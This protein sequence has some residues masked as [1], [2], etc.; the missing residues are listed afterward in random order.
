MEL[1]CN[2]KQ[3]YNLIAERKA[4]LG[5]I[6]TNCV[7]SSEA[8]ERYISLNRFL[9]E[10]GESGIF[11]FSD[12][13]NYYQLY[14]YLQEG[15][16]F[17][18]EK[19]NKPVLVQN[20][21]RE[22]KEDKFLSFL[23]VQ[24]KNN[25]F[26][27]KDTLSHAVLR[28][29]NILFETLEKSVKRIERIFLKEGFVFKNVAIE[30]LS[31]LKEFMLHIEE[32][33]FYQYPYYTDEEYIEEANE[34]RLS[35]IVDKEGKIIAA[36]HL[37]VAGKKAYGWVGI[38]KEYKALYGFAPYILYQQLIYLRKNNIVMCSWVKTTNTPSIQYHNRIGSAWSGQ[39]ED[40]WL[41]E[42]K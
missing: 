1:V 23:N 16:T 40:E 41:L 20:I 12:E 6:K 42:S 39:L 27:Y 13:E 33:P 29:T 36:R 32:I 8:I 25:G 7:L 34:G 5:R 38:K 37:I 24:L 4:E 28:E 35:C 15:R 3:Y 14:Y 21:F 19:K 31:E 10:K 17:S 22:G 26:E 11:F 30:Q 2:I 9:Y 18:F